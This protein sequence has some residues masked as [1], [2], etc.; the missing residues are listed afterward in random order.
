MSRRLFLLSGLAIVA[1]VCNHATSWAY[2]AMFSWAPRYRPVPGPT[3][4]R[5][6]SLAYYGLVAMEKLTVFAVPAFLFVSGFFIAYAARGSQS[7]LNWKM[8]RVRVVNLLIPYTIWSMV[9]FM[10]NALQG[11][12]YTPGEYVDKLVFGKAVGAYY[13]VILLGQLYLLSPWMVWMAKTRWKLLLFGTGLVLLSIMGWSYWQL[14]E[15]AP[16]PLDLPISLLSRYDFF[17]ALGIVYGL[18]TVQFKQWLG[19]SRWSLLVAVI[20]L[21]TLAIIESEGLYRLTGVYWRNS[22]MTL[23]TN[24]YTLAL[25]LCFLAFDEVTI[26]FSKAFY[27]L[28]SKSY[29]I[30]L[31]HGKVIELTARILYHISPWVLGY[32]SLFMPVVVLSAIAGPLLFMEIVVRSP[33]KRSYRYLFG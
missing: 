12:K 32:Q 25:I 13:F 16:P 22:A 15:G 5:V 11:I 4:D 9:I 8:V 26:P 19:R 1:V 7:A 18:R 20:A 24:L 2:I 3:Y 28:G 27:Y 33:A 6:G 29:A 23:P 30:F 31:M 21:G 10:G 17:F 14:F